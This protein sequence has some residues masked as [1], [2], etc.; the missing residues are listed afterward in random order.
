MSQTEQTY[1]Q[2]QARIAE[3]EAEYQTLQDNYDDEI[4]LCV[5]VLRALVDDD[6]DNCES[7]VNRAD[8]SDE[9]KVDVL[10]FIADVRDGYC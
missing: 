4:L 3:L 5:S 8:C 1:Q 6:Y 10:R 7:L 9:R 2:L